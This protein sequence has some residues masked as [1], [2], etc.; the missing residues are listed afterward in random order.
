MIQPLA[1]PPRPH[2]DPSQQVGADHHQQQQ[3]QQHPQLVGSGS[4]SG[5]REGAANNV[6]GNKVSHEASNI[7]S[8]SSSRGVGRDGPCRDQQVLHEGGEEGAGSA[9]DG[10]GAGMALFAF[11]YDL[12]EDFERLMALEDALGGVRC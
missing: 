10:K 1:L 4:E 5:L 6:E 8:S 11:T 3:Q 12:E 9:S 2:S 7:S